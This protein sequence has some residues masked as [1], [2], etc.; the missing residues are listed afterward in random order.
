M[1]QFR[2]IYPKNMIG[3]A[4]ARAAFITGRGARPQTSRVELK[5]YDEKRNL[6]TV[7]TAAPP[8]AGRLYLP[9][10][11]K[12]DRFFY[13]STEPLPSDPEH[14]APPEY[15]KDPKPL[16]LELCRGQLSRVMRNWFDWRHYYKLSTPKKLRDSIVNAKRRF[17]LLVTGDRDASDYDDRC[18]KLFND[19][20][21]ISRAL[22]E[23]YIKRTL[24]ARRN[25]SRQSDTRFG[26][27]A[28]SGDEW[29]APFDSQFEERTTFRRRPRLAP[30]FQTINPRF[31]WNEIERY[32]GSYDWDPVDRIMREAV[33]RRMDATVGP[34]LRWDSDVPARFYGRIISL[35]EFAE[36]FKSYVLATVDHFGN[37]AKR[38][39]VAT[40]AECDSPEFPLAFRVQ[41]AVSASVWIRDRNPRAET[42][43]GFENAFGDATRYGRKL[44]ATP[45]ELA[46]N[47][48]RAARRPFNGFYLETNLG[49]GP[50]STAPRDAMETYQH[51]EKWSRLR[52]PLSLGFSC[53]SAP[54]VAPPSSSDQTHI[55]N[56]N[57][58]NAEYKEN[59]WNDKI[60]Q[61]TTREFV[62]L[63]LSQRRV[64]EIIWTK[65]LDETPN[66]YGD[67]ARAF[68]QINV[69][70]ENRFKES[71]P[72]MVLTDDEDPIYTMSDEEDSQQL[73]FDESGSTSASASASVELG[74]NTEDSP[75]IKF[76]PT[77]GLFTLKQK[78]KPTLAK[79]AAIR[80]AFLEN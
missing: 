70:V 78:P 25:D 30:V 72:P 53:P 4:A 64:D 19:L 21:D 66:R 8:E 40:N 36:A 33:K 28:R 48:V 22:S 56:D 35:E 34:L 3:V 58:K 44:G 73:D 16:F 61:E 12:R 7:E 10:F 46:V 45:Y 80:N 52:T 13:A 50:D 54:S 67:Y 2:F 41:L 23:E 62:S 65:F 15:A 49:L 26:F 38:W 29:T 42:F 47:C 18:F 74:L 27:S 43:L 31:Q 79:L 1:G 11:D 77:S 9:I 76:A 32:A 6:L 75:E 17:A 51:F 39:I 57:V 71:N 14:E 20:C 60:Q 63:A 24:E 68:D 69:E 5:E 59:C 37:S 55:D